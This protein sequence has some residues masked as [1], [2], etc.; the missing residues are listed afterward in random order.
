MKGQLFLFHVV[1]IFE[2]NQQNRDGS[3]ILTF[4]IL[5]TVFDAFENRTT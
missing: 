5:S 2:W 3:C 4:N 1:F